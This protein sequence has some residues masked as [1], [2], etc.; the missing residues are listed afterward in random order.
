M[1]V[2]GYAR[3]STTRQIAG[4]D[5][6]LATLKQAGC[7]R[8]FHE[9][10][11][12]HGPRDQLD[13]A[14]AFMRKGDTFVI[15]RPDRLARSVRDMLSIVDRFGTKGIGV[16]ILSIGADTQTA[17]GKLIL[18]I[19]SGVAEME[20]EIM[21]ERQSAGIAKAKAEGKY[22]RPRKRKAD[23]GEIL[24]LKAEGMGNTEI[25]NRLGV[26]PVTVWRA[27]NP[28]PTTR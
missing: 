18:T 5:D 27:L 21:L 23:R 20:H 8:I 3:T 10:A 25:A 2:I 24:L 13:A 17:T 7:E 22:N 9:H 14:E 11:S 26:N 28:P 4:L 6:Q 12:A 1:S 15:T 16:R 19:L